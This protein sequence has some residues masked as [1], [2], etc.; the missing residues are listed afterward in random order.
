[1]A[2][3]STTNTYITDINGQ[4]EKAATVVSTDGDHTQLMQSINGREVPLQ[5]TDERVLREDANGKVVE[6]IVHKYNPEGQL[7]STER[8]I[9]EQKKY[10][11]GETVHSTTYR[12]DLN[13]QMQ[14]AER[15]TTESHKHGATT[16]S[17]TVIERPT[18]N[19]AFQAVEKRDT[20]SES[21]NGTVHQDETVYRRS[22]N[23]DFYPAQRDVKDETK[24]GDRTIEKTSLYQTRNGAELQLTRQ[25]VSTTT[26]QADGSEVAEVNLY[27][28]SVPGTVHSSGTPQQ[29]YEQDIIQREKGPGGEVVQTLSVRRPSISDPQHLGD[30]QK[31]SETVCTG[32]CTSDSKP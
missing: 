27:G 5:Q 4:S 29:L 8:V 6:T 31:I 1:M 20:V 32:K 28:D 9:T 30:P 12:S 21:A 16:D 11:D 13:G 19:G 17:A 10:A 22:D 24:A 14:E 3:Q 26:K 23:G 25:S 2:A 18:L 15:Q 7:A